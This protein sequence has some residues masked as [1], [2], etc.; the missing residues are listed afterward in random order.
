MSNSQKLG[1]I[2]L[3]IG[4]TKT[5]AGVVLWPSG[6]ILRRTVVPTKPAR[7]GEAV[8]KDTLDLARQLLDWGRLEGFEVAGIGAGV[9]ELVDCEGNV[10]SSCTIHWRDL[11]VQQRLSEIAPAQVESDV[12]AAARAE[13][14]FG[15]GRGH[16]NFVYVTVGTGI[17][18]CLVQDGHPLRGAKGNALTMASSPLSTVCTHCGV[19]LRPV[20]E[21]F[22]S[23]PAIARRFAQARAEAGSKEQST[24]AATSEDVFRAASQ[25]DKAAA[26]ILTSA[27][28]ALGVS[29][30]FLVNVLDPEIIVVGGG[31]GMAGG[32]YWDAFQQACREHIFADNSRG[33]PI[34][35]AKLGTDAGLVGA[36]ATVFAQ[37]SKEIYA[38]DRD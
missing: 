1:A 17:S 23:G 33:L 27:G 3:D 29:T 4:G 38:Y 26:E 21:E 11:P 20:L 16:R 34:V 28:E 9:A 37:T 2:G 19:K 5:A 18:C 12:R 35:S 25:G 36:G 10:T 13:A 6:E 8:L 31:L 30:A 24:E 14:I 7:G 22:A 32:L 15:A